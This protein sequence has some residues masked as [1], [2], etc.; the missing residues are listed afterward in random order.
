MPLHSNY[1]CAAFTSKI[2]LEKKRLCWTET[3]F[4]SSQEELIQ[5]RRDIPKATGDFQNNGRNAHQVNLDFLCMQSS[6]QYLTSTQLCCAAN[7]WSSSKKNNLHCCL[8]SC[9]RKQAK[10]IYTANIYYKLKS[11]NMPGCFSASSSSNV[12]QRLKVSC[13]FHGA[14]YIMANK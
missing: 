14:G 3:H 2:F 4:K 13:T 12:L 8:S 10:G 5:D 1:I 6:K 7:Y 11:R 9:K